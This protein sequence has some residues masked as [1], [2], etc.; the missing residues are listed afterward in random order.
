MCCKA[1]LIREH[2]ILLIKLGRKIGSKRTHHTQGYNCFTQIVFSLQRYECCVS[3]SM[4]KHIPFCLISTTWLLFHFY[5][6]AN[7]CCVLDPFL[8]LVN[9]PILSGNTMPVNWGN[10]R[11]YVHIAG[12]SLTSCEALSQK[13]KAIH[14]FKAR[15]SSSS[16]AVSQS[17]NSSGAGA[18]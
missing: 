2:R 11:D 4:S 12:R 1:Q 9:L 10:N 3:Q 17:G 14:P 6:T 18:V 7:C 16:T 5:Q 13:N 8:T 15:G